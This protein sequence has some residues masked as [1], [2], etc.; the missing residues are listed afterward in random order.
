MNVLPVSHLVNEGVVTCT[1]EVLSEC[2]HC[3]AR[4]H[5]HF[6]L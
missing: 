3:T 2:L 5:Y 1:L 6:T 4:F